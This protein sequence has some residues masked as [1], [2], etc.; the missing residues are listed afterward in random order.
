[1]D[2][3]TLYVGQGGLAVVRHAGEAL[4]VDSHLVDTSEETLASV[5]ATI[6]RLVRNHRVPGFILTGFDADH[7]HPEGV[8]LILTEFQPDW[9]M[10]PTYYKDTDCAT[11]AFRIIDRH[12]R[13]RANTPR[14]LIR[15]SVCVDHVEEQV[16]AGLS[17]SFDYEL[18]SPHREDMD[19]SNNSSLVLKVSGHGTGGF[20]YLITGDTEQL[21]WTAMNRLFGP[22][23]RADV[24]D[25]PHHGS[26]TGVNAESLLL[27]DPNTVLISA[28]V[29]NQYGHPDPQA[30]AAYQRVAEHV[31]ATNVQ[32]GVSLF[33][34][35]AANDF[36]TDLVR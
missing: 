10:Y 36:I 30:V 24:L 8:D 26:I 31:Y 5:T 27:I 29:D 4:I 15:R 21:R 7:C 28:G 9:I 1:M 12:V 13:A 35:Q 11:D 32:G 14:P 25:A 18:F 17:S 20:S 34:R 19:C 33:T 2:V 23:L 3:L 6:K 16:L 22:R